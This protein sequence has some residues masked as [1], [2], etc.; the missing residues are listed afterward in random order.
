MDTTLN[1]ANTNITLPKSVNHAITDI[2]DVQDKL[3]TTRAFLS[4]TLEDLFERY[5]NPEKKDMNTLALMWY[6]LQR[7]KPYISAVIDYV[8]SIA[9]ILERTYGNLSGVHKQ[10]NDIGTLLVGGADDE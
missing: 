7:H 10:L 3:S 8:N 9:D 2:I 5:Y 4:D 6:S 1:Q